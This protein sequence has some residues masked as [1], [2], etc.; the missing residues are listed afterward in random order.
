MF[1]DFRR[2]TAAILT[3]GALVLSACQTYEP[4][5]IDLGETRAAWQSRAPD[6]PEVL[7]AVRRSDLA[8]PTAFDPADGISLSEA[9]VVALVFRPELRLARARAGIAE[10]TAANA[11]LWQDP[12]LGVDV[13]RVLESVDNPWKL[14]S[15]VEFT[16]PISGR[17][18]AERARADA[19]RAVAL[20]EVA[21]AEWQGRIAVREAWVR[22]S[23]ALREVAVAEAYIGRLDEVV[24]LATR[25]ES[26]EELTRAQ[27]RLFRIEAS[28]ARRELDVARGRVAEAEIHVRREMG[29]APSSSGVLVPILDAAAIG[30][31]ASSAEDGAESLAVA[32]AVASYE[33]AERSLLGEIRGQY[34]DLT[35]GP[36]YGD[37]Q[38]QNEVLLGVRVPLPILN[39]NRQGIAE[40]RARREL[41][42]AT[43][44]ITVERI[45]TDLAVANV[46]LATA[47]GQRRRLADELVPL[48]DEEYRD[49]RTIARLGQVDAFLLLESL[50]RQHEAALRL[51][52][53]ERDEAL[54]AAHLAGLKG[55]ER[56]SPTTA[57][58]PA[59]TTP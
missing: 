8:Q 30:R 10:A 18:D 1:P 2:P 58:Q 3:L 6:A 28:S 26:A 57:E 41:A 12:S 22:W 39:A 47:A 14:A 5:P 38:G 13:A 32:V 44:A 21:E 56:D 42:R 4:S 59:E 15:F 46:A 45:A 36:G 34:P 23:S 52:A 37:D 43:V 51:I 27:A 19:A 55:P 40:A 31:G 29:L 53:A 25:L 50:T 49:V 24:A 33:V 16:I 35:I 20:T 11:G 7:E 9:E 17:L 54:A 48:A